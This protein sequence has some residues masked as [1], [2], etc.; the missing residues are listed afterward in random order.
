M[1]FKERNGIYLKHSNK[2]QLGGK[3][4]NLF[5]V[6]R[7]RSYKKFQLYLL[8]IETDHCKKKLYF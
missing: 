5:V 2:G 7:Q 4:S 1:G 3:L 8:K 6:E